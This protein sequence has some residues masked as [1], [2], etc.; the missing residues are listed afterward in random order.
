MARRCVIY[1][2]SKIDQ[3]LTEVYQYMDTTP[4]NERNVAGLTKQLFNTGIAVEHLDSLYIVKNEFQEDNVA[5]VKDINNQYGDVVQVTPRRLKEGILYELQINE[6]KL[7]TAPISPHF[8]DEVY[9][10][11]LSEA[12]LPASEQEGATIAGEVL[13]E[14][15]ET[16]QIEETEV[17]APAME[18]SLIDAF[19]KAGIGSTIVRDENLVDEE[20]NPQR[21][22]IESVGTKSVKVSINP[23]RVSDAEGLYHEFGHLY[24][25]MLGVD[26]SIV[27]AGMNQAMKDSTLVKQVKTAY[28]EKTGDELAKEV[29]MHK[30][31]KEGSTIVRNNPSKFQILLNK[32]FRA[33]GQMLGI[34]PNAAA[35]LAEDMFAGK[36]RQTADI[37]LN[38]YLEESR[39]LKDLEKIAKDAQIVLSETIRNLKFRTKASSMTANILK[40]AEEI[41]GTLKGITRVQ[42]FV[43][44]TT[45]SIQVLNE[46]TRHMDLLKDKWDSNWGVDAQFDIA[47]IASRAV[48]LMGMFKD[49]FSGQDIIASIQAAAEI[50]PE[51]EKDSDGMVKLLED[52]EKITLQRAALDLK[53]RNI[54]IPILS[55]ILLSEKN[56]ELL[57]GVQNEIKTLKQNFEATGKL[58][59]TSLEKNSPEYLDTVAYIER[60]NIKPNSPEAKQLFLELKVDQ[61]L[62]AASPDYR[63]TV[64]ELRKDYVDKSY[65]S[66][67][68]TSAITDSDVNFQRFQLVYARSQ[69]NKQTRTRDLASKLDPALRSLRSRTSG[70]LG[71]T[72]LSTVDLYKDFVEERTAYINGK[73]EKIL[74]IVS[75]LDTQ[76]YNL[77][78]KNKKLELKKK[79]KLETSAKFKVAT[80]NTLKSYYSEL[81]TYIDSISEPM[82]DA[83][84]KVKEV[85]DSL[86][87]AKAKLVKLQDAGKKEQEKLEAM[88]GNPA[89]LDQIEYDIIAQ[90]GVIAETE[91]KLYSLVTVKGKLK[92]ELL[93]PK[94]KLYTNPKYEAVKDDPFYQFYVAEMKKLQSLLPDDALVKELYEDMSYMVPSARITLMNKL[95]T[96]KVLSLGNLKESVMDN[97]G[98]TGAQEMDYG[99]HYL[100]ESGMRVV[101]IYFNGAVPSKLV[102]RDL[103]SILML[104]GDMAHNFEEK[105][106]ILGFV[107]LYS[108]LYTS[109]E[110][111]VGPKAINRSGIIRQASEKLGTPQLMRGFSNA[112][113]VKG[114]SNKQQMIESYINA[115]F[116]GKKY[117]SGGVTGNKIINKIMRFAAYDLLGFN[118]LQTGNQ[119]VLDNLA[120]TGE[121]YANQFYN[122][123]DKLKGMAKMSKLMLDSNFIGDFQALSP[124][125]KLSQMLRYFDVRFDAFEM[126]SGYSTGNK[127]Q[128]VLNPSLLLSP[129]GLVNLQIKMT[130]L[131]GLLASYEGKLKDR[132]GNLLLNENG[133]P[134]DLFDLFQD[135]GDG[136]FE[137]SSEI[138]PEIVDA[139]RVAN[140][141]RGISRRNNQIEAGV[142]KPNITRTMLRPIFLF[143]GFIPGGVQSRWG[144]SGKPMRALK[145]MLMGRTNQHLSEELG[146][147]EIPRYAATTK[148]FY[149]LIENFRDA[150]AWRDFAKVLNPLAETQGDSMYSDAEAVAIRRQLQSLI[151]LTTTMVAPTIFA[152][153][154]DDE[155]YLNHFAL[156]QL[157]RL[158]SEL[159]FYVNP[160]EFYNIAVRSPTATARP[161][162]NALKLIM[163]T[164]LEAQYQSG[165][166]ITDKEELAKKLFYQRRSGDFEKGDRKIGKVI[167]QLVPGLNGL[168]KD[169]E[170]AMKWF[171]RSGL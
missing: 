61:L 73:T 22:R 143:R 20:G 69:Q 146:R 43:N 80:K 13:N 47:H 135:R 162:E 153:D 88:V 126:G 87:A 122:R 21:G 170:Q 79:Y 108:F 27:R 78:I 159:L 67:M 123:K 72:E 107:E 1:K 96:R 160:L 166:H 95:Q 58:K 6:D 121:T 171:D 105:N 34:T 10:T 45:K 93:Q 70:V 11:V 168:L 75:P 2:G 89:I 136:T 100:R 44:Y 38:N 59:F 86:D 161:F 131:A 26:N 138:D 3:P 130:R 15:P 102:S 157:R 32:F 101:P 54:A 65:M 9:G 14:V 62:A 16:I 148:Y 142:D 31:G 115:N 158:R 164:F 28:P 76:R 39:E 97:F 119:F 63:T 169:P 30:I 52:L 116:Y 144:Y 141:F 35:V 83:Q 5:R 110:T 23:E 137:L 12:Q 167:N 90:E 18:T 149:K 134:A 7:S 25:D 60:K 46:V 124:K 8:L 128:K 41:E 94:K 68:F 29:F 56:P 33:V 155:E 42:D 111:G 55:A 36:L 64:E 145:D 85:K 133:N 118:M 114:A 24:V 17:K 152:R 117:N 53:V 92:G 109:S 147:V 113:G 139:Q 74:H 132:D 91:R 71:K 37:T 19:S 165:L 125:N 127:I 84:S 112:L 98:N 104:F 129:Q 66:L 82:V 99:G 120:E 57:K 81:E 77:D 103:G 49:P 150:G 4:A 106:K 156:Y 151:S 48:N 140:I 163:L 154:D 51:S 50:A 40:Q